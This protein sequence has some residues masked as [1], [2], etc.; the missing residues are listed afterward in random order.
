MYVAFASCDMSSYEGLPAQNRLFKHDVCFWESS[1][2]DR[3]PSRF[4]HS[5]RNLRGP[6]SFDGIKTEIAS[7]Y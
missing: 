2:I 7:S 1:S 4:L 6:E 3:K 5:S